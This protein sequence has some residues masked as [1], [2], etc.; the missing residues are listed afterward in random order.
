[1]AYSTFRQ[2]ADNYYEFVCDESSDISQL[3]VDLVPGSLAF[4]IGDSSVYMLNNQREW[5]AL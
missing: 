2:Q 1:M 4:V 5:V 3:P